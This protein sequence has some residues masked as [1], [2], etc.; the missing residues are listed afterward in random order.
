MTDIFKMQG[1]QVDKL[2]CIMAKYWKPLQLLKAID[3]L[4]VYKDEAQGI[5]G[6]ETK[7]HVTLLFGL[8]VPGPDQMQVIDEALKDWTPDAFFHAFAYLRVRIGQPL[9][10]GRD[11][12]DVFWR[13]LESAPSSVE[14]S[15]RQHLP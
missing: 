13:V 15:A 2:G 14:D 1:I 5:Q 11:G 6:I 9:G 12:T 7:S 10:C 4:L 8:I 3:P